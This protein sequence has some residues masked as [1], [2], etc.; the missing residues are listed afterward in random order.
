MR[1]IDPRIAALTDTEVVLEFRNALIALLPTCQRLQLLVSDDQP[2]D[3]FDELAQ[4]LWRALV[5]DTFHW[6]YG[7]LFEMSAY[8]SL[9]QPNVPPFLDALVGGAR[10]AFAEFGGNRT[11]GD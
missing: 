5:V 3:H 11:F 9:E 1:E 7:V 4:Y 8:G 10:F 6:K 2:Y